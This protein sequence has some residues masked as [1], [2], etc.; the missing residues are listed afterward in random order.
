MAS[1]QML[2]LVLVLLLIGI[3]IMMAVSIFQDQ[4]ASAN[5]DKVTAFLSELGSRA[6]KHYRMPEWLGGGG[7]SFQKLTATPAGLAILT[8][9][10]D[11]EI[12]IFSISVAGTATQVTIEGV[13]VEDGDGD[14]VYCT[15]KCQVFADSMVTTILNR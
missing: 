7:H 3:A 6:Q 10:P 8:N 9:I 13:G 14:G 11:N 1:S 15:A 2:L 4:T 5:L 12:G